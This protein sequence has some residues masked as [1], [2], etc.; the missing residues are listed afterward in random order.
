MS[1]RLRV[2]GL[3][4]LLMAAAAPAR[5]DTARTVWLCGVAD[6]GVQL[7]C[8]ADVE[9]GADEVAAAAAPAASVRGTRFPLDPRRRWLVDFWSPGAERDRLE[10]L[11]RA[12][13]GHRSPGCDVILT[14]PPSA[15]VAAAR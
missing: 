4:A 15:T 7:V 9:P 12:T 10:L 14:A 2:L 6:N 13:N 5:A 1:I 3:V 8:V 11:A